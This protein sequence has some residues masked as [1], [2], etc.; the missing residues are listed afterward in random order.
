M[1]CHVE[2]ILVMHCGL[3]FATSFHVTTRHI[4]PDAGVQLS[5][6]NSC[7][8]YVAC[9]VRANGLRGWRE[10]LELL[11]ESAIAMTRSLGETF[12][13]LPNPIGSCHLE[14]RWAPLLASLSSIYVMQ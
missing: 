1:S 3:N 4:F 5:R 14:T 10:H 7:Q 13:D 2:T 11:A 8:A 12:T 9:A 6:G